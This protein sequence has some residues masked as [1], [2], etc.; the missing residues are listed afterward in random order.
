MEVFVE[1][2]GHGPLV[3]RDSSTTNVK[4][5]IP[6]ELISA[7]HYIVGNQSVQTDQELRSQVILDIIHVSQAKQL[8]ALRI[9]PRGEVIKVK[10]F[11]NG[12]DDVAEDTSHEGEVKI[13]HWVKDRNV[14]TLLSFNQRSRVLLVN[15]VCS[16]FFHSELYNSLD[17]LIPNLFSVNIEEVLNVLDAPLQAFDLVAEPLESLHKLDRHVSTGR[18]YL[19]VEDEALVEHGGQR[20]AEFLADTVNQDLFWLDLDHTHKHLVQDEHT[21]SQQGDLV[22]NLGKEV[23][24]IVLSVLFEFLFRQLGLEFVHAYSKDA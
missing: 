24:L 11:L 19:S 15:K 2:L 12:Q 23:P 18:P 7:V 5:I 4:T 8:V 22:S 16:L 21:L 9:V 6:E 20:L 3:L 14:V 13:I 1:D 17:L 10:A